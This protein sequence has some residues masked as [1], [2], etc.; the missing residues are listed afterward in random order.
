MASMNYSD[1]KKKL[2]AA[3]ALLS[4]SSSTV[5]KLRSVGSLIRGMNPRM[6]ATLAEYEKNLGD[7]EK[8]LDGDVIAL[9]AERL[10]ETT[11]EEKKRG[12]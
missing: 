11:E 8:L 9:S 3:T 2:D 4:P 7:L 12:K 10:P 6:D 5:S 1:A